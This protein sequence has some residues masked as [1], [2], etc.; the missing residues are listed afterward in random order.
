MV[1]TE[2]MSSVFLESK[3]YKTYHIQ[4]TYIHTNVYIYIYCIKV[5]IYIYNK[6][7]IS[8]NARVK[9]QHWLLQVRKNVVIYNTCMGCA[10][11]A[12]IWAVQLLLDLEV[13]FYPL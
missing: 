1:F 10:D 2:I 6:V 7:T 13:Q 5:Y 11:V 8:M 9:K 3:T 12:W 4:C